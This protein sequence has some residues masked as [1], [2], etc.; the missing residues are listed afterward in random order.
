MQKAVENRWAREAPI[1]AGLVRS[2]RELN[3]RFLDLAATP[4]G[5]MHGRSG[6]G[7]PADLAAAVAALSAAQKAAAAN[8]PY[9]LFDLQFHDDRYWQQRLQSGQ[10]WR[11]A[12]AALAGA[13]AAD[14]AQLALFYAWHVASTAPLTAQ[15]LLG[16]HERTALALGVV[17][18][19]RLPGL[20]ATEAAHLTARWRYCDAYWRA[21][22]GA[23]AGVDSAGLRRVQLYGLQLAAATQLPGRSI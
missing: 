9:A 7:P 3:H 2:L 17:T 16:M 22:V 23:A 4:G 12:D 8:C 20:A 14:F 10:A 11:I 5:A 21:L 13:P 15:L 18:V 19:D 1:S 6:D